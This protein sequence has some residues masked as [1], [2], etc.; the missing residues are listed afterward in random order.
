MHSHRIWTYSNFSWEL[1]TTLSQ[2][3]PEVVLPDSRWV[4]ENYHYIINSHLRLARALVRTRKLFSAKL[5]EIQDVSERLPWWYKV[6]GKKR[7]FG[8]KGV[9]ARSKI[10]QLGEHWT[11][12]TWSKLKGHCPDFSM[13]NWGSSE[14]YLNHRKLNNNSLIL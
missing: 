5:S 12:C 3:W 11:Y 6:Q 7:V 14:T 1:S 9:G 10:T 2:V 13:I 8:G 4:E